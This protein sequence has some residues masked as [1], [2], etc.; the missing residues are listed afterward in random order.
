MPKSP[1]ET[2]DQIKKT[3]PVIWTFNRKQNSNIC[4]LKLNISTSNIQYS[5]WTTFFRFVFT[6]IPNYYPRKVEYG[7]VHMC[8]LCYILIWY[9]CPTGIIHIHPRSCYEVQHE[10]YHII[11]PEQNGIDPIRVFCNTSSTPITAILHHNLE[12]LTRVQGYDSP[13]SYNAKVWSEIWYY[14]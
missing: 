5:P 3:K 9:F 2:D 8:C 13:G 14:Q 6:M 7:S 12:D 4:N 1:E 10:G 11:D